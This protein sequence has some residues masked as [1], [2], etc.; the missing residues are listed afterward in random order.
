[1]DNAT[2]ELI[3][4]STSGGKI[5][6]DRRDFIYRKAAEN[7]IS[8]EECDIYIDGYLNSKKNA[9][10][11]AKSHR[12]NWGW[13][14]IIIGVGDFLFGM[15]LAGDRYAKDGAG[16]FLIS[17]LLFIAFGAYK[18]AGKGP[19]VKI[20]FAALCIFLSFL[21]ATLVLI[22]FNY[23]LINLL[24]LQS[25]S[26]PLGFFWKV[27]FFCSLGLFG[28]ISKN[29]IFGISVGSKLNNSK[30]DLWLSPVVS[31]LPVSFVNYLNR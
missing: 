23:V 18:L 20:G 7:G 9:D 22:P 13:W 17:G 19:F 15:S 12:K 10:V 11:Q 26:S 3:Q 31:R 28:Y 24:K 29:K 30:L 8:K 1:M 2:K 21:M 5:A 25:F 16:I 27:V 14:L 4:L 6:H